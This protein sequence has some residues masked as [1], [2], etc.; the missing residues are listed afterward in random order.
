MCAHTEAG[1]RLARAYTRE[2]AAVT[3]RLVEESVLVIVD[4]KDASGTEWKAGDRA[5]LRHRAVREAV[6]AQPDWFVQ[7][8]ETVPVDLDLIR[9]LD[10]QFEAELERVKLDRAEAGKRREKALR[11]ELAEQERGQPD[12][13]RRYAA[14][15]R[16]R[17]ERR[18]KA[19]D[20]RERQQI[21]SALASGDRRR[22]G[23]HW[24]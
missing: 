5:S 11:D 21:E 13:E 1:A 7:E 18:R 10:E 22:V 6:K 14:Q 19:R 4:C 20:E 9:Q 24:Q 2:V 23:F 12:L 8:F 3:P 16:A 17:E 15:E